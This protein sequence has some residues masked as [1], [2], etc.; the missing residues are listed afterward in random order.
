MPALSLPK[1]LIRAIVNSANLTCLIRATIISVFWM[2]MAFVN[3]A[4]VETCQVFMLRGD[5]SGFHF[6]MT[7]SSASNFGAT[8]FGLDISFVTISGSFN[9]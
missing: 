7:S 3:Q 2:T 5:M 1:C 6:R 8:I 4:L 9:P